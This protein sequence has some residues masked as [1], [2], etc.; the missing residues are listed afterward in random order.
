MKDEQ[1]KVT[2]DLADNCTQQVAS[3]YQAVTP[4]SLLTVS[5]KR[6][7][8]SKT[9]D[10]SRQ[11][12]Q[13]PDWMFNY[14]NQRYGA[15]TIDGAAD[16][17]NAKCERFVTEQMNAL[18]YNFTGENVFLNPPFGDLEP[19]IKMVARETQEHKARFTVILPHDISTK[20][21]RWGVLNAAEII[22]VISDGVHSGRVSFVDADSG[23]P[24]GGNN[25]GTLILHFSPK[26]KCGRTLYLDK[27]MMESKGN[28]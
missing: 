13:T 10:S 28:A 20:W 9:P 2:F 14:L 26:A 27:T 19:W 15:F 1:D 11:R 5:G 16:A 6:W 25:K 3:H 4:C 8:G 21:A 7:A 23:E 12:W 18:A 17:T 24:V 22:H